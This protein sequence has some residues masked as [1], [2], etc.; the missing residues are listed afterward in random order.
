MARRSALA[1]AAASDVAL[2]KMF[3][4][5]SG[6]GVFVSIMKNSLVGSGVGVFEFILQNSRNMVGG[7]Y[8]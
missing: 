7:I 8:H 1:L 3:S 2:S 4:S 6:S 5:A